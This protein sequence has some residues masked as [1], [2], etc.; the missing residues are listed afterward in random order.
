MD[1][2]DFGNRKPKTECKRTVAWLG[3]LI[4]VLVLECTIGS[5]FEKRHLENISRSG[6]NWAKQLYRAP[7]GAIAI[8]PK[9]PGV[10]RIL[11]VSNSHAETVGKVAR[12]LGELLQNLAPG[13]FEVLDLSE[14]GLFAPNMLQRVLMGLDLSPDAVILAVAYISFSDRMKL[15]RQAH[16]V[17][18]FFKQP[19]LGR[20]SLGF[21]WRNYDIGLYSNCLIEHHLKLY[22]YRNA[23]RDTWERPLA[24]FLK[25]RMGRQG[26]EF[27]ETDENQTWKFPEGY[28]RNLFQW[29][30]YAAGRRH[31]MADLG[32]A[33]D[34]IRRANV[35]LL[36]FNLPID[37]RKSIYA[38]DPNDVEHYRTELAERFANALEYVDYEDIF[39]K[40]FTT[41]DALHPN[42]HGARLHALDIALRLL[43]HGFFPPGITEH[44]VLECYLAMA[45]RQQIEYLQALKRDVQPLKKAGFRRYDLCDAENA[46]R[47]LMRMLSYP[48]GSRQ[49]GRQ[50]HEMSLRIRYWSELDFKSDQ[51]VARH[52][53]PVFGQA[54]KHE[55]RQARARMG[56]FRQRMAE[57]Q[58]PRLE[59]FQIPDVASAVLIRKEESDID[60]TIR[61]QV[62]DY[63][64]TQ[65]GPIVREIRTADG[66]VV[67][68]MVNDQQRGIGYVRTDVLGDGTFL[69]LSK[70]G[71]KLHLPSWLVHRVP[72]VQL[73]S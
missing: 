56:F 23:I 39:P 8:P 18:S 24:E 20:L 22:R 2:A 60:G 63:R 25:S 13:G 9:P 4:V 34:S 43:R 30:L 10:R 51:A 49:A 21:W 7:D 11:Y 16:S 70:M 71:A 31:H 66:R 45:D 17:R 46:H 53:G 64:S 37:W 52:L 47:L 72:L 12:H 15:H 42:W 73:G 69:S 14:P 36:G 32:E 61:L 50:L 27:L 67:A 55:I 40:E 26:I 29:H 33:I 1:A 35:P 6:D 62:S 44:A 41:Y 54:L 19:I 28:D 5:W 58:Q 57:L 65:G 48:A 68:Y 38:H 3:L 59:A